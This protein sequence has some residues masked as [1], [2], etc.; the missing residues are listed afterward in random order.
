MVVSMTRITGGG[1]LIGLTH[2]VDEGEIEVGYVFRV[3]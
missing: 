3:S 1:T 2:H